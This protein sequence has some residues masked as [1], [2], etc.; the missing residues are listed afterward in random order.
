MNVSVVV[1]E[2][3]VECNQATE[4]ERLNAAHIWNPLAIP[5]I[6]PGPHPGLWIPVSLV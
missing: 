6:D 1:N 2:L 4:M 3:G 5:F